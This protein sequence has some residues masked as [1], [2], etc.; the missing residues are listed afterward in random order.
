METSSPE[1]PEP[2]IDD[3]T[4]FLTHFQSKEHLQAWIYKFLGFTLPDCKVTKYADSIP[5]DFVWEVYRAIIDGVSLNILGL[6]GRGSGKT[7][8]VS[9][10]DVLSLCHDLRP[11]LHIGVTTEQS[12]RAREYFDNYVNK[13][14]L[15]QQ[16]MGDE[17][18][19]KKIKLIIGGAQVAF[20]IISLKPER[21]QGPHFSLV[22][23][24]EISSAVDGEV[25]KAYRD[26]VGIL[27]QSPKGKPSIKVS[28][29]S[30]QTGSSIAE[31]EIE[32]ATKRNLK[33]RRWTTID[34]MEKC[35]ESR[36]GTEPMPLY[37]NIL[38]GMKF[39]PQEFRMM[40][41]EQQEGTELVSDTM[42]GCYDCP[43]CCYCQGRARF[44]TSTSVILAKIDDVITK[45]TSATHDWVLSQL[46]SLHPSVE[47]LV[48]YEFD[49][50]IHMPGWNKMWQALTGTVY[51]G[52]VTRDIFVRK[53]LDMGVSFYA[54]EDWGW[55][56]PSTVVVIAVDSRENVY[57]VDAIGRIM[58]SDPNF[59]ELIKEN[60][61]SKYNIQMHAP[62]SENQ[63][64]IHIMRSVGLPVA[65][66][67]KGP[68]SV[69]AGINTVKRWLR[70][71]GTNS[72]TKI[73][74]APELENSGMVGVPGVIKEMSLYSKDTD[75]SGRILDD[76]PPRKEN[77][78]FLDALR[79]IMYWL[80]GR[81]TLKIG[82]DYET[83]PVMPNTNIPTLEEITR[84]F[85]IQYVDN[86]DDYQPQ[87]QPLSVRDPQPVK[88]PEKEERSST[89][90][91]WGW[92]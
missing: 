1:T 5:L 21:V 68:G 4:K 88:E 81:T 71:P 48:Y 40:S 43:L 45:V 25:I 23:Y 20:E 44:Q 29:T 91:I 42:T 22:S 82:T 70:V 13:V 86:R 87:S 58:M 18:N 7:V 14:A 54:G 51:E 12:S 8:A 50:A 64:A 3:L 17:R 15:L 73:Y 66:I 84:R 52:E 61:Q 69:K 49:R 79:Y 57:V 76:K 38:K 74:F 10:I 39:L 2:E 37:V 89:G 90:P 67:D 53:C 65:E 16:F 33:I 30:R 56:H 26:S 63:S 19:K 72:D 46:M 83:P 59:I 31:Q 27:C 47:G 80:F 32:N 34:V 62:D 78:H 60:P 55:S 85:Q 92:T 9:V 24:D 77:D 41:P 11:A 28:I 36:C 6:A 35:S 75:A